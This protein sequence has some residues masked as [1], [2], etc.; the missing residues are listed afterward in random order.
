MGSFL[1][2]SPADGAPS[3]GTEPAR[4]G[5]DATFVVLARP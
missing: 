1:V 3:A 2:I 5:T 4:G